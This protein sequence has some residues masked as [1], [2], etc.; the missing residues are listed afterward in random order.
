MEESLA[1]VWGSGSSWRLVAGTS[2]P[3]A[4][5][6]EARPAGVQQVEQIPA[7]QAVLE[8]F[9]GSRIEAVE[10]QSSYTED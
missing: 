4:A 1:S 2:V 6:S 8:I 9:P 5:V 7:V 10:E 3:K